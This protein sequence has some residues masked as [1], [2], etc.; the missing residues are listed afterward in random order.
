[1]CQYYAHAFLCKHLTFTFAR[2]C[3]PASLI[4]KPCGKRQI[5]QTIRMDEGCEECRLWFPD[6]F[7]TQRYQQ[8]A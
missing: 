8:Q 7:P 1:M 5:W 3:Q 6:K 2:F 4:Q